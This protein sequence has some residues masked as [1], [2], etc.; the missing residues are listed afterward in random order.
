MDESASD[1]REGVDG[2]TVANRRRGYL[3]LVVDYLPAAYAEGIWWEISELVDLP[4]GYQSVELCTAVANQ[5]AEAW[6]SL[7]EDRI[8]ESTQLRFFK[9]W[10]DELLDAS[11]TKH[12]EDD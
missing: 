12:A 3:D 2:Q 11:I 7:G 4:G 5:F 1:L 9:L 8:V 6:I 10:R